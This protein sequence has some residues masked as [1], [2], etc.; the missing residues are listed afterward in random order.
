MPDYIVKQGDCISSIAYEH[1]FFLDTI[2]NHPKNEKL[3]KKRETPYVLL[4]GDIV[5]IPDKQK[6]IETISTGIRNQI[7]LKS[8]PEKFIIQ[9]LD[10]DDKPI[11]NE[12]YEI[13]INEKKIIGT[14]DQDGIISQY[15]MPNV[16]EV[17]VLIKRTE[18][19]YKFLIGK[20]DPWDTT[21]GLQARLNNLGLNCGSVNGEKNMMTQSVFFEYCDRE[22]N[23][24][25]SDIDTNKMINSIKNKYGI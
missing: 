8:V 10:E 2:W 4:E 17:N 21:T 14:T 19:R 24:N 15:I 7:K 5:F 20:L 18:E 25:D 22:Q 23:L 9:L 13:K 6:K 3:R 12:T 16:R 1:G 11:A